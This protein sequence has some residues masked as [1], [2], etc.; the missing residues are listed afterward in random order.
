MQREPALS[1]ADAT[2]RAMTRILTQTEFAALPATEKKM[3][4]LGIKEGSVRVIPVSYA[5]EVKAADKKERKERPPRAPQ[6]LERLQGKRVK[7]SLTSGGDIEG[8][9]KE[10]AQYEIV[11][12]IEERDAVILK[13]II[14]MVWELQP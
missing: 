1:R 14:G 9:L 2:E 6:P 8:L 7:L 4:E 5:N 13:H 10:V 11:F 12:T 3:V